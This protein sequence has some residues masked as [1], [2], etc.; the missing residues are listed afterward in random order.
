M[1][2]NPLTATTIPFP[3]TSIPV[4]QFELI[5]HDQRFVSRIG[6]GTSL[7]S[8][9]RQTTLPNDALNNSIRLRLTG[10]FGLDQ[11]MMA[12]PLAHPP[13]DLYS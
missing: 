10:G 5:R 8:K 3:Q 1:V 11:L 12:Q 4:P 7:H 2:L 13:I 6:W 9:Q